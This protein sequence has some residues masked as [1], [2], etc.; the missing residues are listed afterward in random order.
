[1]LQLLKI[2]RFDRQGIAQD[3]RR[4][5]HGIAGRQEGPGGPWGEQPQQQQGG[6]ER[7]EA[8]GA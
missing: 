5:S 3:R 1:V 6:Q 4:V 8:S 7:S 2:C